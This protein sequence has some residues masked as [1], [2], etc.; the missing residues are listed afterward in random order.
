MGEVR[1]AL[2]AFV[3]E[4]HSPLVITKLLNQVLRRYH[5]GMITTLCLVLLEPA[6]GRLTIVNCGHMPLVLVDDAG[7][8]F[9]G[10]G[11]L[12]LGASRHE[13]HVESAVLA[14]GGTALLFTDGLVEDRH[15]LLDDNL[16]KLR[17]GAATAA[18]TDLEAFANRVLALFGPRE[19]DVAMIAFRRDGQG[20]APGGRP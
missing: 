5:P 19:D 15:V 12:M 14:E 8:K 18:G 7:A 6:S 1:H 17:S 2:R 11:G 10:E 16:E 20:G 4:G 3:S 13:P 9:V